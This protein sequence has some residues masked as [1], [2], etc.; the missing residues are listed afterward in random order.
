MLLALA[1][2]TR[3]TA[4]KQLHL[5]RAIYAKRRL[6]SRN[7]VRPSVCPSVRPSVCLSIRHTRAL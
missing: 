1:S 6:G 3:L 7:S 5:Y 2:L 4:T